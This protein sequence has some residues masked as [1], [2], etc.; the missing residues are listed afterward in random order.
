[1]GTLERSE[2]NLAA[3]TTR[4]IIAITVSAL[5]AGSAERATFVI[6]SAARKE[7]GENLAENQHDENRKKLHHRPPSF[8]GEG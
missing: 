3:T 6:A 8:Q 4:A 1:L 7:V 2:N 5:F